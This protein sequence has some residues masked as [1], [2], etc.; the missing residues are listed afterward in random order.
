MIEHLFLHQSS[1]SSSQPIETMIFSTEEDPD[2][3]I[4]KTSLLHS[5][6]EEPNELGNDYSQNP[7]LA[8]EEWGME[9]LPLPVPA[10][11]RKQKRRRFLR[12]KT[13]A[14]MKTQ[15]RRLLL[16]KLRKPL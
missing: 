3:V 15:R 6:A 2:R 8:E 10:L 12:E 4:I 16:Q 7:S 13:T 14:M 9:Q 11:K 5:T 1:C